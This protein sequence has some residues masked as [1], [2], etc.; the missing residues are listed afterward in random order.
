M[1]KNASVEVDI[2]D[3]IRGFHAVKINVRKAVPHLLAR[4]SFK[5]EAFMK[6][7]MPWRTGTL[8]RGTHA[9][10]TVRP[11]SVA[12]GVNYAFAANIHSRKPQFIERTKEYIESIIQRE[13]NLVMKNALRGMNR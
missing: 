6:P 13:S 7:N 10:P 5:G 11:V 12:A 3:V 4:L 1:T 2:A 8:R 9:H